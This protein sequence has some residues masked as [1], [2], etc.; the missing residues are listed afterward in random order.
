MVQVDDWKEH[1]RLSS[2]ESRGGL[3]KWAFDNNP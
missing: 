3:Y 1:E 2:R